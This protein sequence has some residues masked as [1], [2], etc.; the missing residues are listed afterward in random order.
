MSEQDKPTTVPSVDDVV[1]RWIPVGVALP[2]LFERVLVYDPSIPKF[3]AKDGIRSHNFTVIGYYRGEDDWVSPWFVP[4][5]RGPTHWM[6]LPSEP[7]QQV[8]E[9]EHGR[10]ISSH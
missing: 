8:L 2:P 10:F 7:P 3:K 6:R 4:D 5:G 9:D 1:N